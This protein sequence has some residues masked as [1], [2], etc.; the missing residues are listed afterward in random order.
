VT[1]V[2]DFQTEFAQRKLTQSDNGRLVTAGVN[3]RRRAG[4]NLTGA[5]GGCQS[6]L[7]TIRDAMQTIVYGYSCHV[8][9]PNKIKAML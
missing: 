6:H 1:A 7:E 3:H 4:S 2:E 5:I 8:K 9:N